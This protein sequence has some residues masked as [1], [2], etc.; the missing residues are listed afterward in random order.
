MDRVSRPVVLS[1]D[2]DIIAL[3]AIRRALRSLN[4]EVLTASNGAEALELMA[5]RDVHVILSDMH[6]PQM[7][8]LDFLAEAARTQPDSKRILLIAYA[9]VAS[10]VRAM[11]E[12]SVS[13]YLIKPWVDNELRKIIREAVRIKTLECE[14]RDLRA[15][16]SESQAPPA[17]LDEDTQEQVKK[18]TLDLTVTRAV[19]EKHVGELEESY[20]TMVQLLAHVAALPR[21]ESEATRK[22]L[23]LSLAIGKE[24][25]LD[26]RALTALKHA[27]R[28]HRVGWAAL[29]D[30]FVE[31][32]LDSMSD[33]DAILFAQHPV[34]AEALLMGV[35]HLRETSMILRSQHERWGGD[36]F[37]DGH[38][39][40]AIPLS[41]RI[42]AVCRDYY[43]LVSGRLGTAG[44]VPAAAFQHV[45]KQAGTLYD[46][47]VVECFERVLPVLTRANL[48]C[49]ETKC[50]L[51]ELRADMILSRDLTTG[52]DL[53]LLGAGHVLTER[54]LAT[55]LSVEKQSISP[56]EVFVETS[57]LN[58]QADGSR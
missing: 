40:D 30:Y 11:S 37:P 27:A 45:R 28:L 52:Q 14:N 20:D 3:K 42:L 39:A 38:V 16:L 33:E 1:V 8:G 32:T 29:P 41:A 24:M 51:R 9:D 34:Y 55:L 17:P 6:M 12:R 58:R 7:D 56:L 44:S 50:T 54:N 25:G 35:P 5:D 2:D 49:S 53:L 43:D 31:V 46:P 48:E 36:G 10:T 47:E 21:H 15:R 22:K 4:V 19:F 23:M 18:R 57:P 26:A 13:T